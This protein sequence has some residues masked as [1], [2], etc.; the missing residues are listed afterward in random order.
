MRK[1]LQ[2]EGMIVCGLLI[3]SM[4]AGVFAVA[5]K[6]V[7]SP[8]AVGGKA[9]VPI[10][11]GE[12]ASPRVRAAAEEL[13][14]QLQKISGA[15]FAIQAGDGAAGLAVGVATDFLQL[16]FKE[17][18]AVKDIGGRERY[19]LRSHPGGLY[20]IGATEVAVE[21]AVWDF[22]DRLGYRQFFPGQNWEI[23]PKSTNI[24]VRLNADEKPDYY[25]RRIWYS[26]GRWDYNETPYRQWCARNRAVMGFGL[27]QNHVYGPIIERNKA[28][29]DAH[30]EYYGLVNGER[31]STK[32]CIGNPEVRRLVVADALQRFQDDPTLDCVSVE[33]SDQI[34]WCECSRCAALGS[35]TDRVITL[36]NEVAAAVNEKFPGKYVGLY[37][38]W[39]HSPPPSIPVRPNVIVSI[40]TNLFSSE[41]SLEQL[42]EGWGKANIMLGVREYYSIFEWDR[43]LPGKA[44]GGNIAYLK[45]T[46]PQFHRWGA[47]FMNAESGDNWGANGLGYYLAARMLWRIEEA[48]RLD[49][50]VEDFLEKSF[51][52]A[53]AP[54]R[55]FYRLIDGGNGTPV[56][57][58]MVG[59]MFRALQDARSRTK[60]PA[61]L[62]RLN[63]LVL[64]T[65]YVELYRAYEEAQ[66]DAR[67][68]AFEAVIRYAYRIRETMMVS[69]KA[70]YKVTPREDKSVYLPEEAGEDVPEGKNP[71]KQSDPFTKAEIAAMVESGVARHSLIDFQAVQ[72]S[73][74]LVPSDPLRLP[75]TPASANPEIVGQDP[76]A[77]YVW[78]TKAPA[79]VRLRVASG[80][81]A[82]NRGGVNIRL[83]PVKPSYG[84][85]VDQAQ[86]PADRQEH[87]IQL[88]TDCDGLHRIEVDDGGG[89]T[90]VNPFS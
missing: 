52:P 51:G 54:M 75:E 87:D 50:L 63:D 62:A 65:H 66:G 43:D 68:A 35:I 44:Q 14:R 58:D 89:G 30:P 90:R 31:K 64:Y 4:T 26:Y 73:D 37:A 15:A 25:A 38:Y 6:V 84:S 32:I 70:L 60:D 86:A 48:G 69:V 29:F 85:A 16:P 61:I 12:M 79:D 45:R 67:Q 10:V 23:V 2:L 17:E 59:R 76:G 83:F 36:A 49:E 71:W 40:A 56:T 8:L 24:K 77:F 34:D 82:Q 80:L 9:T 3:Q 18:L 19:V 27:T 55:E 5:A 81:R 21:D 7:E 88:M 74:A 28:V 46:I 11:V 13:G 41:Y 20:V 39:L 1:T 57:D 78:V 53:K 72:Y 22:L 47:R 33:P 42:F